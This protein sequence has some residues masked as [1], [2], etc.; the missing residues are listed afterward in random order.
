MNKS[1]FYLIL[2]KT[3]S[4]NWESRKS[5]YRNY[6]G[7]MTVRKTRQ[8]LKFFLGFCLFLFLG[9]VLIYITSAA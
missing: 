1:F 4:Q 2:E 6:P 8:A 7:T 3:L 5:N 9:L